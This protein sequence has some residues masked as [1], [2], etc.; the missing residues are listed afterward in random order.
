M[1]RRPFAQELIVGASVDSVFGPVLLFGQGGTAVEVLADRAI[2]LPPLNG[3][4]AAELIARTRVARLLAGY[5]DH[6]PARLEAIC[7]VLVA[8]SQMLADLPE[9]AELDINPLCADHQGVIAL[10]ARIRVARGAGAGAARFAITPYPAELVETVRWNDET[11]VLRPIRPEDEPQHRAFLDRVEPDDLRLRF[12]SARPALP[13]SELARLTQIDYA[14][15][16]AF[17]AVRTAPDGT[18]ETL[19]VARAVIDPDNVDAELGI[20]VRSDLKSHGLGRLLLRRTID[21]LAGRGSERLIAYV[22][23]ENRAMRKLVLACGFVVDAA[24]SDTQALTFVL[25]LQRT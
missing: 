7:D 14:R 17:I 6:P 15:E 18:S 3:V 10:D 12:F 5:R 13:R 22:L 8:L 2:A 16:M 11:I 20:I 25:R 23:R 21:F 1:V 19:G 9:L 24:A 4:L